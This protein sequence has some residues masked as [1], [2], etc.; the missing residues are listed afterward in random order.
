MRSDMRSSRE[1]V[2]CCS[3]A[4]LRWVPHFAKN[5]PHP[6]PLSCTVN[7]NR[8][9]HGRARGQSHTFGYVTGI[10]LISLGFYHEPR[11][12]LSH[13]KTVRSHFFLGH[14]RVVLCKS[15][16]SLWASVAAPSQTLPMVDGGWGGL[17]AH[18][19]TSIGYHLV[20]RAGGL[21]ARS[22]ARSAAA[23][24]GTRQMSVSSFQSPMAIS[25]R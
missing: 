7:E 3:L 11:G 22:D 6:A 15:A 2:A 20:F 25:M 8:V 9:Q 18:S 5:L 21:R 23:E 12:A 10:A 24:S 1:R 13:S 17:Q 16:R 14:P 4:V 19:I